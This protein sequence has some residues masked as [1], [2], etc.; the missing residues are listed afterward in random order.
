MKKVCEV[1]GYS[2]SN[3]LLSTLKYQRWSSGW[4]R[5]WKKRETSGGIWI[6]FFEGLDPGCAHERITKDRRVGNL[7]MRAMTVT[8]ADKNCAYISKRREKQQ[9]IKSDSC[10]PWILQHPHGN[11]LYEHT[12]R[13]Y[14]PHVCNTYAI[15][16]VIYCMLY[17]YMLY[18]YI[19]IYAVYIARHICRG[20]LSYMSM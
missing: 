4:R 17:K 2:V 15:V 19:Y 6:V 9:K 7:E 5:R 3:G 1:K 8:S 12:C 16:M 10:F 13:P 20:P 11:N 18:I 14:M